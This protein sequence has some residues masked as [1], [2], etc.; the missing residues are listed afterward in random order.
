MLIT[1]DQI[2]AHLV[3]DYVLQSDWLATEKTKRL[4]VAFTHGI[5]YTLPFLLL[6]HSP[7]ALCVIGGS[8]A[9]IDRYRIA[10]HIGWVKNYLAPRG[11]NPP[12][13]ECSKTGYPESKPPFLAVW[14][15]ILVDQ[16]L[17]LLV[18]GLALKLLSNS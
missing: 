2:L 8:H 9:L 4:W 15:M 6:T 10:R 11:S 12:W 1:A 14:L 17:H 13:K 16:V 3:G 18:N 5:I 7:L